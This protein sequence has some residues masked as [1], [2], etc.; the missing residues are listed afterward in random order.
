MLAAGA[1]TGEA[2]ASSDEELQ[3]YLDANFLYTAF[4][5]AAIPVGYGGRYIAEGWLQ[6][7]GVDV[8]PNWQRKGIGRQIVKAMLSEGRAR[9]L[10]GSTLTTDRWRPS[11]HRFTRR[12]GSM[13]SKAMHVPNDLAPFS[14]R[15][16]TKASTHVVEVA[17]MLVF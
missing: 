2:A 6:I 4:D 13:R 8:H 11:M 15:K 1:V 14:L 5:E 16:R 3:Q 17:M 9:K 12:S 10:K 7:G